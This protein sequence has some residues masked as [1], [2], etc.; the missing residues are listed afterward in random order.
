MARTTRPTCASHTIT[1]RYS[2]TH[3]HA[4]IVTRTTTRV[5]PSLHGLPETGEVRSLCGLPELRAAARHRDEELVH[6]PPERSQCDGESPSLV[7]NFVHS[8]KRILPPYST[9]TIKDM[10]EAVKTTP[11]N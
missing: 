2:R 7:Y 6:P 11:N 3:A 9:T 5:A 4:H 8:I 1:H 10:R